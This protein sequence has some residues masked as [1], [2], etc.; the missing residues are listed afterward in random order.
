MAMTLK[1]SR[2]KDSTA[3]KCQG[4]VLLAILVICIRVRQ[5]ANLQFW[6]KLLREIR[7]P[8]S[9]S[10][11][12]SALHDLKE[13]EIRVKKSLQTYRCIRL[14]NKSLNSATQEQPA[15]VGVVPQ[16]QTFTQFVCIKLYSKIPLPSFIIFP[17]LAVDAVIM[18]LVIETMA[19]RVKTNS[20]NLLSDLNR[21]L[22][23]LPVKSSHR[24]ELRA[25]TV[26]KI[27]F[28]HNFVDNGTPLVIID[29][30][31]NQTVSLLLLT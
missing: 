20:A 3:E 30:C 6:T 21:E 23:R 25:C 22:K 29:F 28:G 8:C 10:I 31:F 7:V 12:K 27:Q 4:V 15:M 18:N 2:G 11:K 1:I 19:A 5:P 16:V 14:I 17:L 9:P 24:K 26:G 13:F